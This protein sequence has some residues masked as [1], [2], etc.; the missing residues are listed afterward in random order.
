MDEDAR[1]RVA[2]RSNNKV[3]H[4][5]K[6]LADVALRNVVQLQRE[7]R[8]AGSGKALARARIQRNV[9]NMGHARGRKARRMHNIAQE[10]PR[11][12]DG[13]GQGAARAGQRIAAAGAAPDRKGGQEGG[14]GLGQ[15]HDRSRPAPQRQLCRHLRP[16]RACFTCGR[17]DHRKGPPPPAAASPAST[18]Q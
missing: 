1:G 6:V 16:P 9:D 8:D 2:V 10:E 18:P 3:V 5:V 13:I 11:D 12:A 7:V 14:N 15:P 17:P 4:G